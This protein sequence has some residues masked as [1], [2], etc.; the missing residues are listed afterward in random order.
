MGRPGCPELAF[1][2]A[3]TER[4]RMVLILRLSRAV[5]GIRPP[6]RLSQIIAQSSIISCAC[7]TSILKGPMPDKLND[8]K[9]RLAEV[10]DLENAAAVLE[11]DQLTM[12][13]PGGATERADQSATLQKIAH[14][15]FSSDEIGA[16]LADLGAQ[17][18]D[19][20]AENDD[21]A[22]VR[23][24]AR[25]HRRKTQIPPRL[26]AETVQATSLGQS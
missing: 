7:K 14:E 21:A 18:K 6:R 25:L 9:T 19:A 26:V 4:K 11:W 17:F 3:S 13:P 1:W 20:P 24:A 22:L 15:K 10:D 8:L 5:A 2:T 12:M 23:V 16:L